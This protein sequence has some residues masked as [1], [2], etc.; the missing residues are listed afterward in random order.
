MAK[1]AADVVLL[2]DNFASIN[3][4]ISEGKGIFYNIKSFVRFQLSVSAAALGVSLISNTV[5]L[6]LP[7][8]AMQI[9]W[10]NIIKCCY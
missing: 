10:I 3:Y 6:P 1:E 8:N 9:L 4:A 5:G 7:L 2:D